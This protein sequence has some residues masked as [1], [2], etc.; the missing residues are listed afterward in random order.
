MKAFLA[1]MLFLGIIV[2]GFLFILPAFNIRVQ[3][4]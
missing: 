3:L 4:P 2:A 1:M